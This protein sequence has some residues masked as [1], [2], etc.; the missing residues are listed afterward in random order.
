MDL[1]NVRNDKYTRRFIRENHIKVGALDYSWR[2]TQKAVTMKNSP[3]ES[4]NAYVT[5]LGRVILEEIEKT[6]TCW[7]MEYF[8]QHPKDSFFLWDIIAVQMV[9]N[10]FYN[11][12]REF[13]GFACLWNMNI[14]LETSVSKA[15]YLRDETLGRIVNYLRG[16]KEDEPPRKIEITD[17]FE[18][19]DGT[20]GGET[21]A[22]PGRENGAAQPE[23]GDNE[24]N[25]AQ[26]KTLPGNG[27]E[28]AADRKSADADAYANRVRAEAERVRAEADQVR[29]EAEQ[30]RAEAEQARAEAGQIRSGAEAYSNRVRA[31]AEREASGFRGRVLDQ[32]AAAGSDP[33]AADAY[34][35][36]RGEIGNSLKSLQT[37]NTEKI[38][39]AVSQMSAMLDGFKNEFF[40]MN[41]QVR[42][43]LY[44]V[45]VKPLV[46]FYCNFHQYVTGTAA[47]AAAQ[48]Q[49]PEAKAALEKQLGSLGR[50]LQQLETMLSRL[51]LVFY[52]PQ[53]GEYYDD[54]YHADRTGSAVPGRSRV[55]RC[56]A[57]GIKLGGGNE[58]VLL[59][60]EIVPDG[61]A[62]N[63]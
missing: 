52:R 63:G 23:R 49:D 36:I 16:L 42:E 7:L 6:H 37:S 60:A 24:E 27:A 5:A 59:Q 19:M 47:Y 35:A 53:P 30:I 29:A 17:G 57:P 58:T 20:S 34:Y 28:P 50:L 41:R 25:A 21:Q 18:P 13:N 4:V 15:Y 45:D 32:I 10:R 51:G 55:A 39:N 43:S 26:E 14:L 62:L 31:D 1:F 40:A 54:I 3:A 22:A 56:V 48:T 9:V 44:N 11:E 61:G 38:E 46:T 8:V 33:R 12:S 2:P